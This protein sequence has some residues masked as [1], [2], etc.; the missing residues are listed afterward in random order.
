[1]KN[2]KRDSGESYR[3]Y[4]VWMLHYVHISLSLIIFFS[5]LAPERTVSLCSACLLLQCPILIWIRPGQ[6]C[7]WIWTQPWF[8]LP[9]TQP[10]KASK[11]LFA[12]FSPLTIVCCAPGKVSRR[13]SANSTQQLQTLRWVR[14]TKTHCVD[15]T[16]TVERAQRDGGLKI[17]DENERFAL[18]IF[19]RKRQ[20]YARTLLWHMTAH[21]RHT[22]S[23]QV[24]ICTYTQ[25]DTSVS[26]S[27]SATSFS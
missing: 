8:D 19:G 14:W 23:V 12:L 10:Q 27:L 4:P 6:E 9:F 15:L 17:K 24:C 11:A 16:A 22:S 26:S 5:L 20:E 18:S 25:S 7:D 13:L 1:M 2:W 21:R 3:L